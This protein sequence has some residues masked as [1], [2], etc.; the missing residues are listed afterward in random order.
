MQVFAAAALLLAAA[1]PSAAADFPPLVRSARSGP[2]SAADTWEGGNLPAAGVRVQIRAGHVVVYDLDSDRPVRSLFV[3]GTLTFDP[4]KDTRLVA[5]LIKIQPGDDTSEEG[6]DCSAHVPDPATDAPRPALEVGTPDRPID[7]KHT[8][9]IRLV[10][11]DGMDKQSCPALVCCGGRMDFHG[12]PLGRTWVKLGDTGKKGDAALNCAEAVTGWRPGDRLIVTASQLVPDGTRHR[13]GVPHRV[14]YTEERTARAIDGTRI[15]L[16]R[17]LEFEHQGT[18]EY[19]GEVAD[20]SRNVVVESADPGG[21]RGHTMV[22]R[23]SAGSISY[24][25]FRHLG[26]EGVLGRYSLHYHLCGD[27]MRGSSVVGASIWDS[28]NRWLTIHGTN[29]LVVRDCVGYQSVGHGFFLEDGTEVYNVLDRNLAVQAF[30][31]K[32]LPKQALPFDQNEGAGFWWANSRNTFTRNVSCENDRYGFRFE[33][34]ETSALKL[35]LPVQQ[36]DGSLKAVDIRTLPFVRFEDNESHCEGLYG[37]NLGEG[38]NRAGPDVRHPFIVRRTRLWM[39]HY[40]F[41]PEVPSLLVEDMKIHRAEYGVYH[42]NYDNHVY[43]DLYIGNTNTEPFN[44]GHDDDSVQYGLLTVDG[45]TFEHERSGSYM[46]LIQISDDNPT[47]RAATHFRNVRLIDWSG[48]KARALVN[49]GGGPRPEPRTDRGVPVFLHDWFGPGRHAKVVSTRAHDFGAD[50]EQY[51]QEPLLTGDESRVAEVRD[52]EFPHLLD[53]V[54][55][56]PPTTVITYAAPAAGGKVVV[57]GVAADDSVIKKVVV[58][59]REARASSPNF[60]EWEVVLEAPAS[61][62]FRVEAHAEDAA[63]NFEKRPHVVVVNR[64]P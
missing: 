6:F 21:V 23:G 56:L 9:T 47:G 5:G 48:D 3:A 15:T 45:L 17:P 20:L 8:A 37:F 34:T 4:D 46:P 42:P 27:S 59:G 62:P 43:R 26:K 16:D 51:R 11:F 40:A 24:A 53:P 29:Y 58:N 52:V 39:S 19:R 32:P 41:R 2:W 10:Y 25:E 1:A 38:V 60:A 64:A 13:P 12:A 44:R 57:R 55:D 63:G 30:Q 18:G 36:P 61:G 28:R 33:A 50:G 22:H 49:R 14:A 7:V 35:T 54:D 31:G